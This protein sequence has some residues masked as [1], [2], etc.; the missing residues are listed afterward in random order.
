MY[1]D[2][3][4]FIGDKTITDNNVTFFNIQ[5]F[6]CHCGRDKQFYFSSKKFTNDFFVLIL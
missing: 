3:G 5:T 2:H 6:F 4:Y 1:L